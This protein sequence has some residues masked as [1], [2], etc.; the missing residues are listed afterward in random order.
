[1]LIDPSGFNEVLHN[2]KNHEHIC[3]VY[4]KVDKCRSLVFSYLADGL[5]K[6]EK[7]LYI[8]DSTMEK[9]FVNSFKYEEFDFSTYQKAGQLTFM[10]VDKVYLREDVFNPLQAIL[11]YTSEVSKAEKEGYSSV[12]FTCDMNWILRLILNPESLIE[13]EKQLN[14][15][16]SRYSCTALCCYDLTKIFS[17]LFHDI[18]ASHSTVV[19]TGIIESS[20]LYDS[21]NAI[22]GCQSG[23]GAEYNKSD[24]TNPDCDPHQAQFFLN[25]LENSAQPFVAALPSG[26]ISF[27]NSAFCELLGFNK[28]E[29]GQMSWG[30]DL[31]PT[32]FRSNEKTIIEQL[33]CTGTPQRYEKEFFHK[34][35]RIIPV[36]LLV[37]QVGCKN[38]NTQF[39]Y[40]FVTDISKRRQ[41]EEE[42]QYLSLHDSL[43]GLYNRNFFEKELLRLEKNHNVSIG[44][45]MCD[46]D[47]LKFVNDSL[48]DSQG[49]AMLVMVAALLRAC[50]NDRGLVSRIGEDEFAVLLIDAD[51]SEVEKAT[52][53]FRSAIAR[54]RAEGKSLLNV[55]VG[56]AYCDNEAVGIRDLVRKAGEHMQREKLLHSESTHSAVTQVLKKTLEARDFITEG[57]AERIKKLITIIAQELGLPEYQNNDLLLLAEFHDIGKIGI[58]DRILFKPGPLSESETVE[59]QRHSEIGYR[60]ALSSVDLA[61]IADWILKHHEWW[62]GQGYPFGL[63]GEDIP[64]ECRILGIIDAYDAMTHN[65]PYRKAMGHEQAVTELN[66]CA[67]TQFDPDLIATTLKVLEHQYASSP[68]GINGTRPEFSCSDYCMRFQ[69]NNT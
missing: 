42:L 1:M 35:G 39:Y 41:M 29:L 19:H 36:E 61:P 32:D 17:G 43:T 2:L 53:E 49:D 55:S 4:D 9:S 16:I 47:G 3:L 20:S 51:R 37:H 69:T 57:H 50:F 58:P 54:H 22:T 25:M 67:G 23:D 24:K 10:P 45:I 65:R 14:C 64:M 62:N 38:Q 52:Q 63:K 56:F 34:D 27:C 46:L 68:T 31:T 28:E 66:R 59:M 30:F 13:Y 40:A 12:R 8:S 60:I 6:N 44:L 18:L 48:G 33:H 15:F 7:C 26:R 5:K 21:P 11:F